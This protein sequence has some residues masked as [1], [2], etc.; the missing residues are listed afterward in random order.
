METGAAS[1]P[2]RS[3]PPAP[4]L[5]PRRHAQPN[6]FSEAWPIRFLLWVSLV[7]WAE[8][9]RPTAHIKNTGKSGGLRRLGP[10]YA[11]FR[12]VSPVFEQLDRASG[13]GNPSTDPRKV[14][15]ILGEWRQYA[16]PDAEYRVSNGTPRG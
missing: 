4:R 9:S 1:K 15:P 14:R 8:S 3:A 12:F 10:P 7:G 6:R 2:D 13:A 11:L 5:A 16:V